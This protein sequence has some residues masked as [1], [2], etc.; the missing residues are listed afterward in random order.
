MASLIKRSTQYNYMVI[1]LEDS[2]CELTFL[3]NGKPI[4][5]SKFTLQ[6]AERAGVA[7][8]ENWRKYPRNM[9][10][11]R[12]LSNGVKWYCPD[13]SNSPLYT[14]DELGATVDGET[15]EV[16]AV[17]R[18]EEKVID[19]IKQTKPEPKPAA[20]PP[21]TNGKDAIY[22]AVVAAGLSENEFAAKNA[23]TKYCHTGYDTEEKA[24]TWMTAYRDARELGGDPAQAAKIANEGGTK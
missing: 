12:A 16:I 17:E 18:V 23:L 15:G 21:Q 9:L 1:Q 19:V 5:N 13:I 7:A 11:A 2:V 22:A 8:G 10:F 24:I 4:G 20:Q 14:P 3:E 6:D